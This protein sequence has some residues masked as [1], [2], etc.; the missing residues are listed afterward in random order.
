MYMYLCVICSYNNYSFYYLYKLYCIFSV[1]CFKFG[2]IGQFQELI[3][4]KKNNIKLLIDFIYFIVLFQ[5]VFSQF[6]IILCFGIIV[7]G[8]IIIGG[9]FYRIGMFQINVCREIV[10]F[11][12]WILVF[13]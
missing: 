7:D 12:I 9:L 2:Y 4:V 5:F 8:S 3:K 1:N 11:K 10:F 13:F 6:F